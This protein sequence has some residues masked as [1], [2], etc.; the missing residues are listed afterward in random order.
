MADAFRSDLQLCQSWG[1]TTYQAAFSRSAKLR[2]T[3]LGSCIIPR[4]LERRSLCIPLHRIARSDG[5]GHNQLFRTRG[6]GP[7]SCSVR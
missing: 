2:H 5:A 3:P 1:R 7:A 4:I 6:L